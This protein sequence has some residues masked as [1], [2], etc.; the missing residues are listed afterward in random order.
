MA[1]TTHVDL[2][3]GP[4]DLWCAASGAG[5]G[6]GTSGTV[7]AKPIRR[8]AGEQ[9]ISLPL[10]WGGSESSEGSADGH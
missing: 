3:I 1:W 7:A 2:K 10:Q 8:S 4:S 9:R 6:A 5:A